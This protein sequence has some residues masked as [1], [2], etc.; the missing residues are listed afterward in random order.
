VNARLTA[1]ALLLTFPL[2]AAGLLRDARGPA[3]AASQTIS[4]VVLEDTDGDRL[5]GPADTGVSAV[6]DLERRIDGEV[7]W[8][9]SIYADAD[10]R[11]EFRE[12]EPGDYAVI[13]YWLRPFITPP[14]SAALGLPSAEWGFTVEPGSDVELRFLTE[15]GGPPQGGDRNPP[16]PIRSTS[17]AGAVVP[18]IPS[19]PGLTHHIIFGPEANH[20]VLR[21]F[22]GFDVHPGRRAQDVV[23]GEVPVRDGIAVLVP[24][25]S[26][27]CPPGANVVVDIFNA[28]GRLIGGGPT[29]P[30][31][32]WRP[33]ASGEAPRTVTTIIGV[34]AAPVSP[35]TVGSAGL[36]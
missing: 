8:F 18:Q 36:R 20:V 25:F 16:L 2:L 34:P 32:Q 19:E 24:R 10:G 3:A 28:A 6:I 15:P 26:I 12:V 29:H 35:P 14:E 30:P 11:F 1:V 33:P 5:I 7:A 27:T 13:A 31:I 22:F 23:C 17:V 21:R 4:G 9:V